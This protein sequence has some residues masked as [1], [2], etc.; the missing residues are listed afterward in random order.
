MTTHKLQK[1][2]RAKLKSAV[3]FGL[4]QVKPKH[5]RDM[6]AVA[7]RNRDNL[8]YAW[9]V[10]SQ[11]VCDGCALGVAGFHDWTIDGVHLCM[12]RLNLLRLNTMP[13]MDVK[14]LEDVA[15]L[16]RLSNAELRELGRLPY[17]MLREKNAP[18]FRR[19][20]WDEA[21]RRI[22]DRIRV[23][24][25][26]R[27]AFFVTSRGVTNE[28][29][30]MAQKAARFLGTNN[31]DNAARLCHSP[32]T[33]AMKH[34]L[35]VA[36]TTCS[37]KDWYGTDLIIF[38]GANPANDQ[39][40]TTKYLH[41]AKKLGTKV[42]MVNPYREPGME[43]YW[44][45][46]TLSSAAFGTDIMDY[47]FPVSTG[48]DIAFLCGVLKVMFSNGWHD[49]D[50]I[51]DHTS[52]FQELEA[53]IAKL[54]FEE[55]EARCGLSRESMQ[56]FAELIHSARNAVLVWSMGITQHAFG[57]D[58]VQMILNLGLTKGFVGRDKCGLMP[59]RGHSSVQGGA[60]MGAYSTVFPGGKAINAENAAALAQLYGFPIPDGWGLTATEMVEATAKGE[61]DLLYCVGGNFLRTL[62]E[63]EQVRQALANAPM[64]VHQD[65]ILTDQMLI[66]SKQETILLPAKTRYEQDDGGIE[67]STERR[68]MFS[69]E[70]P[71]QVG[72]AR[73]EWKILRD[74]AAATYPERAHLLGCATG[75]E[76]R[77]EIARVV[78]FYDGVQDLKKTGDAMQY[79]GPH[80]CADWKFP[81][82][83]GKAHFR[84][85]PVPP[86]S[87]ALQRNGASKANG[88]RQ[89]I[90]STRR[91]KQFN[92]LV[93]AEI[94]PING[95]PRDAVLMSAE[96]AAELELK[97]NDRIVLTNEIGR[98]EGSVY[99]A[100]IARGNLQIHWPEGNVII[101]RGVVDHAGGVP[102]YNARVTVE[103]V[104]KNGRSNGLMD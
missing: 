70:I 28:V 99:L 76:M 14:L 39:P 66:E 27:L 48:G 46:S 44:V 73:A 5:F 13:A 25:P 35:G 69:P 79:I 89:F 81:T 74:L 61:I 101:R 49:R 86:V 60:E 75:W 11:G 54:E 4:G 56:E 59:I 51:R 62:P 102:D 92:S 24:E 9:K 65:I 83:D 96:D 2:W 45:P 6:A 16:E 88:A 93:Y 43:R 52:G 85:V 36:A 72:E 63:P 90:V 41:E 57:A 103:R 58:A 29:Y 7:W 104:K 77:Q 21:L 3:P 18:G 84:M 64:R 98:Y 68:I 20:S 53:E 1:D 30:Y 17:P 26:K 50:F 23:S 87:P 10:L 94:D 71:R 40:V 95:A 38:F 22:A 97:Q 15:K 8:G 12:T 100:P 55:L 47:W 78:P 37:Y 42:V 32:S 67:T 34:A 19:I 80:L 33:N 91:G 31:V 82:P